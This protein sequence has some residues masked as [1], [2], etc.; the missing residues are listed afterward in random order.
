MTI[1]LTTAKYRNL[2][3][4]AKENSNWKLAAKYYDLAIKH[5]PEHHKESQMAITD[6]AGLRYLRDQMKKNI[7][8]GK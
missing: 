7:R 1:K 2:A 6:L 3:W 8:Y 5:Y 4:N